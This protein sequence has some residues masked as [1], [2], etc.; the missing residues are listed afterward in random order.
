[1]L[2][3]GDVCVVGPDHG[4]QKAGILRQCVGMV[5]TDTMSLQGVLRKHQVEIAVKGCGLYP[6]DLSEVNKIRQSK[7]D[8]PSFEEC[9]D[10]ERHDS[11]SKRLYEQ[12]KRR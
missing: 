10:S 1:M 3:G 7:P 5:A 4:A 9:F 6:K 12:C 8:V 2:L 11:S